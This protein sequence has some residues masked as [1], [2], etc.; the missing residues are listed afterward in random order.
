MGGGQLAGDRRRP[1]LRRVVLVVVGVAIALALAACGGSSAQSSES[2][3]AEQPGS[4]ESTSTSQST[5]KTSSRGA[6]ALAGL[7]AS[8]LGYGKEGTRADTAAASQTLRAYFLDRDH[9]FW[10]AA[11]SYLSA[12]MKHRTQ[13][14]GGRGD[15]GCGKGIEALTAT[16]TTAEGEAIVVAIKGLRRQ[17][18]Q[19]FLIYRTE[20]G[21]TNAMLMVLEAGKWK[22]VGVNPTPLFSS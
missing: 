12:G 9:E 13:Q 1:R 19:A 11:C 8:I 5:S 6:K 16:A 20:A 14:I 7:R 21:N 18:H 4:T 15:A 2:T 10:G 3:S 22:L 17:D